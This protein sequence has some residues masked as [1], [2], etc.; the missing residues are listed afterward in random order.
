MNLTKA[1]MIIVFIL[2]TASIAYC[3]DAPYPLYD[4]EGKI[5]KLMLTNTVQDIYVRLDNKVLVSSRCS[6][7]S[8]NFTFTA[9]GF[10]N[11]DTNTVSLTITTQGNTKVIIGVTGSCKDDAGGN[12]MCF[13]ITQ[14]GTR[15]GG[16]NGIMFLTS[17]GANY[18]L[19]IAINFMTDVLSAG[20]HTFKLQTY[21]SGG[22]MTI[23][24]NTTAPLNFWVQET[25]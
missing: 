7:V 6:I 3:L 15:L 13:D 14:D 24:A 11:I 20:S 23:Y 16:V 8:G 12:S 2:V 19:P 22:T 4:K 18:T 10:V 17:T 1:L 5:N 9:S 21:T 25:R